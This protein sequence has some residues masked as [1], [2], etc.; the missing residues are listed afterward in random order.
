MYM[1]F[2]MHIRRNLHQFFA[3]LGKNAWSICDAT[4]CH[5][6]LMEGAQS[7][8]LAIIQWL[9]KAGSIY[10]SMSLNY[11]IWWQP[12]AALCSGIVLSQ[13]GYL[14]WILMKKLLP[15]F[16]KSIIEMDLG[17]GSSGA[18]IPS[19]GHWGSLSVVRTTFLVVSHYIQSQLQRLGSNKLFWHY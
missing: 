4:S 17:Y 6:N 7:N 18:Y 5:I 13:L 8:R 9:H 10:M 12:S 3:R 1:S 11:Q 19:L 14:V 2:I 16:E 15:N